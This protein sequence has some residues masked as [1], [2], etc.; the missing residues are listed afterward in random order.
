MADIFDRASEVEE[1]SRE[2]AIQEA[3][4]KNQ[5]LKFT[6]HCLY[7]NET[8]SK[9]RFCSAECREDYEMEQ[10]CHRISGKHR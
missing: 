9:G 10:K 3:R 2:I 8:I 5:P 6:G 1:M 7:C 4:L